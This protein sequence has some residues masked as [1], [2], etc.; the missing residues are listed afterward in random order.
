MTRPQD[1]PGQP[2]LRPGCLPQERPRRPRLR[3]HEG[4]ALAML[5]AMMVA[6]WIVTL[7]G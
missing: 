3:W 2:A 6:A 4:L 5:V 7:K 1:K